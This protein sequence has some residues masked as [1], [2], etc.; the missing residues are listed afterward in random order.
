MAKASPIQPLEYFCCGCS[1]DFGVFIILCVHACV[2][3]MYIFT[4]VANIVFET[5]TLGFRVSPDTQTFNCGFAL[6]G[7]PFIIS[8]FS[9]MKY[10]HETHLRIYLYWLMLTFI[11]DFVFVLIDQV[12]NNCL[13]IPQIFAESGGSFA[14]GVMR[15]ISIITLVMFLSFMGYAVFTVWSRCL[16]LQIGGSAPSLEA[17]L[18]QA[19]HDEAALV[20]Q[21]RSG[22]LGTGP[23]P[24]DGIPVVYGSLASPMYSG[25]NSIFG[26]DV[27]DVTFPPRA[28]AGSRRTA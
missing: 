18:T 7:L 3:A 20:Y 10:Q 19:R 16:E 25:S 23:P 24:K 15:I 14:C 2:S 5:P 21:H 17:L 22:L 11:I 9:G 28:T 1:L 4:T 13:H 6:A 8:G 27:H 12:K 26:G